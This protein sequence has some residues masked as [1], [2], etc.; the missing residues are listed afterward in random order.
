MVWLGISFLHIYMDTQDHTIFCAWIYL[1][2]LP[3][4]QEKRKTI[5]SELESTTGPLD[6]QATALTTGPCLLEQDLKFIEAL[7]YSSF[8]FKDKIS[9]RIRPRGARSLTDRT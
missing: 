9:S 6:S 2:L 4:L 7:S 8:I 5:W 1:F 3:P